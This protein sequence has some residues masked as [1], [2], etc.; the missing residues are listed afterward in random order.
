ML[1]TI[2]PTHTGL[3]LP[4]ELPCRIS[5]WNYRLW[6]EQDRDTLP[7]WCN[8]VPRFSAYRRFQLSGRPVS[9]SILRL[10]QQAVLSCMEQQFCVFSIPRIQSSLGFHLKLH[11]FFREKK[12]E[13]IRMPLNVSDPFKKKHFLVTTRRKRL[14]CVCSGIS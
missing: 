3:L 12:N 11:F 2:Y 14:E 5:P 13:R 7:A 8:L 10:L 1:K 9:Q 4:K 6:H